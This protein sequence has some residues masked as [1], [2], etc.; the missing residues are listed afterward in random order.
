MSDPQ[1]FDHPRLIEEDGVGRCDGR[2][3]VWWM[4]F[5]VKSSRVV[6]S[7]TRTG[8]AQPMTADSGSAWTDEMKERQRRR[9]LDYYEAHPEAREAM[10]QKRLGSGTANQARP[11]R[12][13]GMRRRSTTWTG[14]IGT[15]S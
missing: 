4:C 1:C 5:P 15:R 3:S 9:M 14:A 7:G 12:W 2:N 11:S 13:K 10:R 6:R 8:G